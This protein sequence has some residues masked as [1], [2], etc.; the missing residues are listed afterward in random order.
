MDNDINIVQSRL[1]RGRGRPGEAQQKG[2]ALRRRA[3]H[4]EPREE[5]VRTQDG[6]EGNVMSW[7]SSGGAELEPGGQYVM[8]A[9]VKAHSEF[10]GVPETQLTRAKVKEGAQA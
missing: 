5:K 2:G 10:Q 1:P 9:T 8:D 4:L 3:G 6:R 7:F